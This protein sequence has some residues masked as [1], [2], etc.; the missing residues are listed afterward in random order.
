MEKLL[1]RI[2]IDDEICNGRPIIRGYRLTVQTIMEFIL[3]G[4]TEEELLEAY[5]FLEKADIE[6]CKRLTIGLM[7][8]HFTIR[9]IAP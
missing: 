2:T 9:Q 7:D 8:R 6:A 3:A 5:P 4:S 1:S